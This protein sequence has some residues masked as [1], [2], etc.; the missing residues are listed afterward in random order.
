LLD[1]ISKEMMEKG[2]IQKAGRGLLEWK[3]NF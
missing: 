2:M 3:L 1:S